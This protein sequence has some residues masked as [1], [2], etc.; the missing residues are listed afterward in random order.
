MQRLRL[1]ALSL[2]VCFA[3]TTSLYSQVAGRVTGTVVDA[4]GAAIPEATV[5]LQL[6]GSGTPAYST[7]TTA[8]GAFTLSSVNPVSYDLV[9]EAK[10][11]LTSKINEVKVDPGSS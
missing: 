3:A 1:L 7:K 8:T 6:P 10:G 2:A 11:F 4:T 5:S 9:I